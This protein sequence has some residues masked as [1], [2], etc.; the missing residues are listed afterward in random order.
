MFQFSRQNSGKG[1]DGGKPLKAESFSKKVCLARNACVAQKNKV[2]FIKRREKEE[3]G[4]S[5]FED[6]LRIRFTPSDLL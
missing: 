2:P 4:D 5:F 6:P 3:Y 1:V